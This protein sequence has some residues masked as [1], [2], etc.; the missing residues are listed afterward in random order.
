MSR[1]LSVIASSRRRGQALLVNQTFETPTTGYDN[2]ETWTGAGTGTVSPAQSA[3]VIQGTQTLEINLVSQTGSTFT[4][5]TSQS[6]LFVK[7]QFQVAATPT[8]NAVIASIRNGTTLLATLT[9][10]GTRL[11]TVTASG[12]TLNQSSDTMPTGTTIW[13]WFEYVK[14]TGS[15]AIARA[16]WATSDVKPT[17]VA[18]SNK[19][20]V[21][22]DG[23][24]T[25]NADR[26]YLGTTT[27]I[28]ALRTYYDVV[29]ASSSAF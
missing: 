28:A 3:V 26:L 27:S 20:C 10:R 9:S 14:G 7:F 8:S 17:F 29:Q 12:G 23:T 19:T 22:S 6:S 24:S 15:N 25:S 13:I 16:G 18:S 21:S 1:I 5:F 2:G 11:L 4:A